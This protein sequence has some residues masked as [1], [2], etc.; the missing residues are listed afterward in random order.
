MILKQDEYPSLEHYRQGITKNRCQWC[1]FRKLHKQEIQVYTHP[2]G[3][4][5][6]NYKD[7]QWLYVTCPKCHCEWALWKLGVPR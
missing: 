5:V 2:N 7:K 3:W 6:L 4:F 1:G